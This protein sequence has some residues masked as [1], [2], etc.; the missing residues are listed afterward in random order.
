MKIAVAGSKGSFS[1][2]V[3]TLYVAGNNITDAEYVYALDSQGVFDALNSK[4]ADIGIMPIYNSTGGLVKMTMDAIGHN[5]FVVE[6]TMD[7]PVIQCLLTLPHVR[8][9]DI[10][11]VVSHEQALAQCQRYFNINLSDC[12]L[13]E[14]S[15]T[16]Q[17]AADLAAGKLD[18]TTAVVAPQLCAQLYGLRLVAEGIQDDDRNQTH[19]IIVK[20][21]V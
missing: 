3:G 14:Y 21:K 11:Q 19:F 10:R 15:D 17:A 8:Q 16:A 2:Q 1:H 18:S 5:H 7:M 12:Q 4:A 6:S 20:P 13:I 9:D